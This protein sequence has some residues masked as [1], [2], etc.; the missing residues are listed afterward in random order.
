MLN[1][2]NGQRDIYSELL[3][4]L[5]R[6]DHPYRI[7]LKLV[8][9]SELVKPLYSL[10][11]NKGTN[12][13][14][15]EKGF[16][17]LLLQFAEDLSDREM[18]RYLQENNAAKLFCG[19]G[20]TVKTPDHSYFGDL[21]NRIGVEKL[22]ELFNNVTNQLR[23][24]N[25]VSDTFTF[26]DT[27]A[28]VSK[29]KLWKE[30]DKAIKEGIEKLNN[31]NVHEFAQD[32]EARFGAKSK[33][34]FWFGF[35]LAVSVDM[36]QGIITKVSVKPANVMDHDMFN[37]IKPEQGAVVGDKGFDTNNIRDIC[38]SDNLH[39]MVI[40]KNNRKDKNKDLDKFITKIRSPFENIFPA[41]TSQKNKGGSYKT[42][43]KGIE[44]V[45]FQMMF[46]A[47]A[48]NLMRVVRI[49]SFN[50]YQGVS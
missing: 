42:H 25:I 35:K 41:L 28:V 27:S 9:F 3:E 32:K 6:E 2:D 1:I 31:Q 36:L 18:E 45:T 19:F 21:R 34:S 4:S 39:F 22:T 37:D 33:K 26:V 12:S 50:C 16:K 46:K 14:P 11:S 38:K 8:N 23:Q 13:I 15:V 24:Q 40:K 5:V 47:M 44:K 49:S 43:F 30:R 7:L 17:A 20:L 10:Y 48:C 29:V